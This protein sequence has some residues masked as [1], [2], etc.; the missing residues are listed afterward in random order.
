MHVGFGPPPD[1]RVAGYSGLELVRGEG[2]VLFAETDNRSPEARS[3]VPQHRLQADGPSATLALGD[4][5]DDP[6]GD[7]LAYD[8][9][10]TVAGVVD[11]RIEQGVLW[12]DPLSV[13]TTEVEVTATDPGGLRATQ[14]FLT[15]VVPAPEPDA[16]NIEL[17]FDPGFTPEQE[18][19]IRRA[20]DRWME[21][22]TGDLPDVP[23]H[24]SVEEY[25]GDSVRTRLVGVIDDVLIRIRLFPYL[26]NAAAYATACGKREESGLDFIGENGFAQR[27]VESSVLLPR[28]A[29]H[30]IGHVLGIGGWQIENRDT[31]PHFAGPLAVEAFDA[32]GGEG[33]PGGKVPVED[34]PGLGGS[35]RLVHWRRRVIPD[36]VM[37]VGGGDLVTAI[38]LQAL[39]DRGHE[40]DLSKADP[41]TLPGHAQGDVQGAA[42]AAEES[43]WELLVDDVIEGPVVVVDKTGK[44]IRVIQR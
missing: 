1:L 21:V 38:T 31:D 2:L 17:Y 7:T 19:T 6:D 28:I 16:F 35:G 12:M 3:R 9:V 36:D 22:V 18:A 43:V 5:F 10:A 40:V 25:C 34:Q 30:E 24:G 11:A 13:D 27:Y 39:A 37:S 41:Y 44:V 29:L 32:A 33:Y 8:A 23:V 14:R 26:Q 42:V 20:A 4:Y 15:W